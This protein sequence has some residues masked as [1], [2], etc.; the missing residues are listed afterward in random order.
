ME[1]DDDNESVISMSRA[2]E[3]TAVG[4]KIAILKNSRESGSSSRRERR[5][6]RR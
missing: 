6:N 4:N 3:N 1:D 2:G 5:R